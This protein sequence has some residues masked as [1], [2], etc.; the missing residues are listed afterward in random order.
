MRINA[1]LFSALILTASQVFGQGKDNDKKDENDLMS[2]LN[3]DAP[4]KKTF[5]SATFKTT[6]IGNGHSIENVAKGVLD[7]RISHRFGTLNEGGYEL[8]GLDQAQ[9]R[10]GLD[11]G[12][13]NRFMLGVGRSSYDKEYDG[14]VKYKILRQVAENKWSFGISYVGTVSYKTLKV[15]YESYESGYRVA[16]TNQLLLAKK[17]NSNISVQLMPTYVHYNLV[18]L[19]NDPNDIFALGIGGRVKLTNRL[20]LTGE[21]YNQFNQFT[22]TSNCLTLGIDIET[23]GH[24]FQLLF[25]N[26]TGVTER[27]FIGETTGKWSNGDIHFGFN[28]SRVF[29]V[30]KPKGFEN[31]RTKI[32]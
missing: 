32:W 21:Y 18:A 9:M 11:Y 27:N 4:A 14:F 24:V 13:T 3:E 16:Y 12:V 31:S 23:G 5:A 6:R 22:G 29:T 25:T 2:M 20:S 8:Y 1:I 26:S 15:P 10:L 17:I 28:I 19:K 30:I 7:V